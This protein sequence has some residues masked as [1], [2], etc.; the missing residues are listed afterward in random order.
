MMLKPF[1]DFIGLLISIASLL[2]LLIIPDYLTPLLVIIIPCSILIFIVRLYNGFSPKRK[3]I[4]TNPEFHSD[5]ETNINEDT[6]EITLCS[7]NYSPNNGI[8]WV[9]SHNYIKII[10]NRKSVT[11]PLSKIQKI[12]LQR[13]QDSS[14]ATLSLYSLITKQ[15]DVSGN[16]TWG[17]ENLNS[18]DRIAFI[19]FS[20]RDYEIAQAVHN[21]ISEKS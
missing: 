2:L 18:S 5:F 1:K 3:E 16:G 10:D 7:S 17:V 13:N 8:V 9:I 4:I 11:V 12:E 6:K 14:S 20:I 21:R 19:I 15:Y